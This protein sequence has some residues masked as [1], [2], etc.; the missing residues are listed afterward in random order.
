MRLNSQDIYIQDKAFQ[1]R[2]E[3][4]AKVAIATMQLG[5]INQY[6]KDN[7]L[8]T[9]ESGESELN[10]LAAEMRKRLKLK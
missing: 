9:W 2:F 5:L 3:L 1:L 10:I 7:K 8:S 6:L 4:L